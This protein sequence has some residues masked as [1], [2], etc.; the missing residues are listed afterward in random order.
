[1]TRSQ[2]MTTWRMMK[3]TYCMILM[4]ISVRKV[5]K[6]VRGGTSSQNSRGAQNYKGRGYCKEGGQQEEEQM[7]ASQ[8]TIMSESSLS[9]TLMVDKEKQ[10]MSKEVQATKFHGEIGGRKLR[11][12]Q[13]DAE[14]KSEEEGANVDPG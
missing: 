1:M 4:K 9:P 5:K 2:M 3:M 10:E 12:T 8:T 6:K 14:N 11:P 7:K 13:T